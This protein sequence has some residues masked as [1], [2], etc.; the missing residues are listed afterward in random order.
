[1]LAV[2]VWYDTHIAFDLKR[3][4]I[5]SEGA[6]QINYDNSNSFGDTGDL[7]GR[8]FTVVKEQDRV[9]FSTVSGEPL[10]TLVVLDK[11]G[12]WVALDSKGR[13]DTNMDLS[14]I[15][16]VHWIAAGRPLEP[17][18]LEILMRDY[19][20]PRLLPQLLAGV[21]FPDL[22][23]LNLLNRV[24]PKVK[25]VS[26]VRRPSARTV[27]V[28]VKV[29]AA[30]DLNQSNGK[31][32]SDAYDL[33]LFRDG[34]LVG[35][36]PQSSDGSNDIRDWRRRT[37]L[38]AGSRRTTVTHDFLVELPTS[39]RKKIVVFT[40]Y[41]YNE[42]RVKSATAS[43]QYQ[44][45]TKIA[46]REARAYVVAIGVNSYDATA[47]RLRFAVRDAEAL[48]NSLS[49]LNGYKVVP[50]ILTSDGEDR[51]KWRA[52][53]ANI[54]AVLGRLGGKVMPSQRLLG[55]RGVDALARATPDDLVIITFSG[56]GYTT[57]DGTF[58]LLAS[59]SGT[60]LSVGPADLA[61]FVSSE[62]LS[63]WLRPIDAGQMAMIIDACH[64]AASVDQPGF[65]PGPMGD[66]GFGQ[67]AYDK[68]MRILAASQADDVA[69]ESEKLK[70]GLLTYALVHDGLALG[71]D[72]KRA[73]DAN[74][75]GQLTLGEW[76]RYGEQH[77]PA[78]FEDIKAGRKEPVYVGRDSYV[79]PSFKQKVVDHAQTPALFDFARGDALILSR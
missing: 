41:A 30:N 42:D 49:D 70:Q 21:S 29:A 40:A 75:D 5:L 1:V 38:T 53:K 12:S 24:Q 23:P 43:L 15:K 20:Q 39:N 76:L 64:S 48:V 2:H 51:S 19:Y 16:G 66:R 13:F 4:G 54:R 6:P 32:R 61:K 37:L 7:H 69:L 11:I 36:W 62:E 79:D 78:L 60:D 45:P 77:T 17:L 57:K 10:G 71:P 50:V 22:P 14:N 65:K 26:V 74:H 56:H 31:S 44:V 68:A 59:D 33:R 55:V 58:Y 34:T 35:Q 9:V 8:L 52:T 73:A 18:P 63:E 27:V 72:G 28:R 47:R 3:G 67:L 25:I 46:P